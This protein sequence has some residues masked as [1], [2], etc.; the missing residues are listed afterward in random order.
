[1]NTGEEKAG[2]TAQTPQDSVLADT[3]PAAGERKRRRHRRGRRHGKGSGHPAS[4]HETIVIERQTVSDPAKLE[5]M[6]KEAAAADARVGLSDRSAKAGKTKDVRDA[7]R[8]ARLIS[9]L[10]E[11]NLVQ[12]NPRRDYR[13][14]EVHE[15]SFENCRERAGFLDDSEDATA[16]QVIEVDGVIYPICGSHAYAARERRR[17]LRALND[18]LW[19]AGRRRDKAEKAEIQ[20]EMDA[21]GK[22]RIRDF[23]NLA[24][25]R[26]FHEERRDGSEA[27][28]P[29]P[30]FAKATAG[31]PDSAKATAGRPAKRPQKPQRQPK[32]EPRK[33]AS[34]PVASEPVASGPAGS[35]PAEDKGPTT[36]RSPE[37]KVEVDREAVRRERIEA[38]RVMVESLVPHLVGP[39]DHLPGFLKITATVKAEE[40]EQFRASAEAIISGKLEGETQ[41]KAAAA[42]KLL[43]EVREA[44]QRHLAGGKG[45]TGKG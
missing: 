4:A 10:V 12:K 19:E 11:G 40:W 44:H 13:R 25:A 36:D 33:P 38:R 24:E 5:E 27:S 14:R 18:Q 34:K 35:R 32:P 28:E 30:A 8:R 22:V 43:S 17:T 26:R 2:D 41:A 39:T 16:A 23:K 6:A 9:E 42:L 20:A 21:L 3:A 31:R 7:A 15:C 45:E 1:M 37:S 29:K